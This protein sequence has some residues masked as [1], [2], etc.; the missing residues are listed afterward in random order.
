[1]GI[2]RIFIG[3][4]WPLDIIVGALIGIGSAFLAGKILLKE[5]LLYD[6]RTNLQ[7]SD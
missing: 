1:M 5:K 4:H 2:A 3:V 7:F 6:Y